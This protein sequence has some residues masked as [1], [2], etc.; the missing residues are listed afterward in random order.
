M[1]TLYVCRVYQSYALEIAV[2]SVFGQMIEFQR[3]EAAEFMK[4]MSSVT[5]LCHG[6]YAKYLFYVPIDKFLGGE[7]DDIGKH[8]NNIVLSQCSQPTLVSFLCE[9]A[10]S[11]KVYA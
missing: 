9:L 11:W 3:G 6:K 1:M 7:F 4:S 5:A 10:E 8:S 2:A